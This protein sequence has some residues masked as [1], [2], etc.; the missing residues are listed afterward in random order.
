M[1]EHTSAGFSFLAALAAHD[2]QLVRLG[3]LAQRYFEKDPATS[4]I[5]RRQYRETLAQ[6]VAAKAGYFG[7]RRNRGPIFSESRGQSPPSDDRVRRTTVLSR[8]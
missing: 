4:P 8:R 6:L 2:A 3:A 1:P 5:K 7:I